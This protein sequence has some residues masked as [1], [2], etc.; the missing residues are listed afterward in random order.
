[1]NPP[2]ASVVDVT[3]HSLKDRILV[4]LANGT[5]PD[6]LTLSERLGG[7]VNIQMLTAAVWSLQK[8]ALVT[9]KERKAGHNSLLLKIRLV[10]GVTH[11]YRRSNDSTGRHPIGKDLTDPKNHH[12]IAQGGPIEHIKVE[13]IIEV[14][15]MATE[16]IPQNMKPETATHR[17]IGGFTTSGDPNSRYAKELAGLNDKL[18]YPVLRAISEGAQTPADV[19]RFIK[20]SSAR[21][22]ILSKAAE[23]KGWI[24]RTKIKGTRGTSLLLELTTIGR[25]ELLTH[26]TDSDIDERSRPGKSPEVQV[27]SAEAND[28]AMEPD[29]HT[30][31]PEEIAPVDKSERDAEVAID[32]INEYPLIAELMTRAAGFS[33][34]EQAATILETIDPDA[35]LLLLEKVKLTDLEKE[36]VRYL[37]NRA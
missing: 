29:T 7:S 17:R 21:A 14:P 8:Q 22:T 25:G 1:M 5:C 12:W 31:Y 33:K 27:I 26:W 28:M 34:Y 37:R 11:D 36:V 18:L 20:R 32:A 23:G 9:F 3:S 35:A 13:P 19:Q 4:V 24:T 10:Q 30:Q 2:A 16:P 15:Q 6:I